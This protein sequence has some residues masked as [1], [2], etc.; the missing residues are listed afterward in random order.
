MHG[1]IGTQSLVYSGGVNIPGNST[2]LKLT[3]TDEKKKQNH[4]T[5]HQYKISLISK[6]DVSAMNINIKIFQYCINMDEMFINTSP[7]II[8]INN[9]LFIIFHKY[10][11]HLQ[12][13]NC[14]FF[15]ILIQYN[16]IISD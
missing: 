15:P 6:T 10:I 13:L 3:H 7:M 12:I 8:T 5:K 4:V 16:L 1:I 9:S 11:Y 2:T 14:F